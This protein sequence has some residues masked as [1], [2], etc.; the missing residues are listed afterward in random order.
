MQAGGLGLSIQY[1]ECQAGNN[2]GF[3]YI[4]IHGLCLVDTCGFMPH[5][6]TQRSSMVLLFEIIK[7][8]LFP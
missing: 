8:F 6:F 4:F 1:T 3:Q 5:A 7:L 2:D